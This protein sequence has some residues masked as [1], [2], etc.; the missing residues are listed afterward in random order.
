MPGL[1]RQAPDLVRVVPSIREGR[2]S[3]AALLRRPG[4]ESKRKQIDLP[5]IARAARVIR[6]IVLLRYLPEPKL[7]DSIQSM[8]NKTEA[9]HEFRTWLMLASDPLADNDPEDQEQVIKFNELL[10]NSA[11]RTARS[12]GGRASATGRLSRPGRI[13]VLGAAVM[14]SA[15]RVRCGCAV[16]ACAADGAL[17]GSIPGGPPIP[18]RGVACR[19]DGTSRARLPRGAL[20]R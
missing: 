20:V 18:C 4:N 8:T 16:L 17:L 13:G 2:L 19:M 1:R 3:S 14:R 11:P 12:P 15:V 10:A 9:F 5:G 7:R 6:T